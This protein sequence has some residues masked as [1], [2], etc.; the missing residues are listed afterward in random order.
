MDG[1][2]KVLRITTQK[3]R[4]ALV[5]QRVLAYL[6]HLH[7]FHDF[8]LYVHARNNA[9]NWKR[10]ICPQGHS[11]KKLKECV[12]I[13]LNIAGAAADKLT[14]R[15]RMLLGK[16][17]T[18]LMQAVIYYTVPTHIW[19]PSTMPLQCLHATGREAKHSLQNAC[20]RLSPYHAAFTST[21]HFVQLVRRWANTAL[22]TQ[23]SS[24]R[25]ASCLSDW[26]QWG[27]D[28]SG[29]CFSAMVQ[30]VPPSPAKPPA[31]IGLFCSLSDRYLLFELY[32]S[33]F[34]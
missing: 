31:N 15:L 4:S 17:R 25:R 33:Y 10:Y 19:P 27:A 26:G 34:F 28:W 21:I 13:P 1:R 9:S 32:Y 3:G 12:E 5:L 30:A 8:F 2:S 22:I 7:Q 23:L 24:Q 14:C 20:L 16:K 29:R 6:S 11:V 18:A